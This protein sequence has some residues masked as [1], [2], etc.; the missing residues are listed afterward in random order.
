M[1]SA[2]RIA[3]GHARDRIGTWYSFAEVARLGEQCGLE[4]EL[5]G[6]VHYPYRFHVRMRRGSGQRWRVV[7]ARIPA[8]E[9][10]PESRASRRPTRGSRGCSSRRGRRAAARSRV[11]RLRAR[12]RRG[13]RRR[14]APPEQG[15]E[16]R[17][18]HHRRSPP[19]APTRRRSPGRGCGDSSPAPARAFRRSGIPRRRYRAGAP[20]RRGQRPVRRA[21]SD[22]SSQGENRVADRLP[23]P[24]GSG[25]G[26]RDGRHDRDTRSNHEQHRHDGARHAEQPHRRGG[27]E[28]DGKAQQ[29]AARAHGRRDSYQPEPGAD[30]PPTRPA[31]RAKVHQ[32]REQQHEQRRHRAVG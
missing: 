11:P 3:A 17:T 6:S 30:R 20:D 19:P 16:R 8:C 32:R 5:F 2:Y 12:P 23:D 31:G 18:C 10:L 25:R 29:W 4:S 21:A 7:A 28:S 15:H 9:R 13:L 14:Q 24:L 27:R 22:R 1:R 26:E